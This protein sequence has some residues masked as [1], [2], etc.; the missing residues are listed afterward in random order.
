MPKSLRMCP[1]CGGI[2]LYTIETRPVRSGEKFCYVRRRIVCEDCGERWTTY[3]V[4]K[5]DFDKV[6]KMEKIAIYIQNQLGSR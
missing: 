2:N 1:Q 4:M 5:E 3:E 6:K